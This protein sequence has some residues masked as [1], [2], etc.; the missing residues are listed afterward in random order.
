[1]TSQ[2]LIYMRNIFL[3]E[4]LVI[5]PLLFFNVQPEHSQP[6]CLWKF[7]IEDII[8]RHCSFLCLFH[9]LDISIS[10]VTM[11][12]RFLSIM[13]ILFLISS[14]CCKN[15]FVSLFILVLKWLFLIHFRLE[16]SLLSFF[17]ANVFTIF[18]LCSLQFLTAVKASKL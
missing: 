6:L 13:K 10:T 3:K 18:L 16:P 7:Y 9:N 14:L 5:F 1:M 17:S 15:I 11:F 4:V 12:C 2:V 8:H